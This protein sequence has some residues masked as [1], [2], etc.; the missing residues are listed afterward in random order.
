MTLV[1]WTKLSRLAAEP[2]P[3]LIKLFFGCFALILFHPFLVGKFVLGG[4]DV[5]YTHYPNLLFGYHEFELFKN[6]SLWNR[7]IFAGI[8]FTKSMH[9]HYL[10]PLYWPVFLFPEK[11]IFHVLTFLFIVINALIGWFWSR[12]AALSNVFSIGSLI[13]GIVAQ[14]GMF[15]WFAMTTFIAVPMYLYA[16]VIIYLIMTRELRSH[17]R[18]YITLSF[19]LGLLLVTPHPTYTLGFILPVI[20]VFLVSLYPHWLTP[21]RGFSAIFFM[22]C[23]T[24]LLFAAYRLVPVALELVTQGNLLSQLGITS[25]NSAYFGL[26]VSNPLAFG[27]NIHD[28]FQFAHSLTMT[29]GRHTQMHNA[30]YFGVTPLV[31]VYTALRAKLNKPLIIFV[32][33]Y[34]VIQLS[35]L[36]VQP[37]SEVVYL[38]FFPLGHEGLFRPIINITFLFLLINSLIVFSAIDKQRLQKIIKE[39]FLIVLLISAVLLTMYT[40]ILCEQPDLIGNYRFST[41]INFSRVSIIALLIGSFVI[42]QYFF[43]SVYRTRLVL[44]AIA[45]I[46][47]VGGISI[48]SLAFQLFPNTKAAIAI[49]K[50]E[51]SVFLLCSLFI[52]MVGFSLSKLQRKIV[53]TAV[54]VAILTVFLLSISFYSHAQNGYISVALLGWCSF[55]MLLMTTLILLERYSYDN[56]NIYLLF[57][58]FFILIV[59]DLLVSFTNYSYVN[60]PST[61]FIKKIEDIYPTSNLLAF[62]ETNLSNEKKLGNLLKNPEMH[63][64]NGQPDNWR[65]G[66]SD[67]ALCNQTNTI[68]HQKNSIC[69][70][71]TKND[72]GR[73][74]FQDV[75]LSNAVKQVSLGVWVRGEPGV[76]I[77]LFLTS[78]THNAGSIIV[79]QKGDGDWHWLVV[80]L[81][82]SQLFQD[83][84]AHINLASVGKVE[85]YA[86]RLVYGRVVQPKAQPSNNL[87]SND[88]V[89]SVPLKINLASYRINRVNALNFG[90]NELMNNIGM[91]VQ[92]PSYSGVDSDL[93]T[94]YVNFLQAF[95]KPD[96]SWFHRA[97]LVSIL[98]NTRLLDLLGVAYDTD[99][100]SGIKIRPNAISRFAAFSNYEVQDKKNSL[101]RL[102]DLAFDPTKTVV[103]DHELF[104]IPRI[105]KLKKFQPLNYTIKKS[106][107]LVLKITDKTPRIVLFNDRFSPSWH[108]Y[109]NDKPLKIVHANHLFMAVALPKGEGE[110]TFIFYPILFFRLCYLAAIVTM[111]LFGLWVIELV[112]QL[113]AFRKQK[114]NLIMG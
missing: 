9:A 6:F 46:A 104:G 112:V 67:I 33:I 40:R 41:I 70:L 113:L 74:L 20:S 50:G 99:P 69:V 73:N 15:F 3:I 78:P 5:L 28:S 79:K 90:T 100:T 103:L 4:T 107:K 68:K 91:V 8:D 59:C 95:E 1:S 60:V 96:A 66:G 102:Q 51:L 14:A 54:S 86:P 30:L 48:L 37:L 85:I 63:L 57:K 62:S 88:L 32:A 29:G 87:K 111:F 10:N 61:P 7:Y 97:G 21:W 11:Y 55:L 27:I 82:L 16:T 110:L 42:Y 53:I 75:K 17:L 71:Y 31:L 12:I 108:A 58:F 83:V 38:L 52:V 13:V 80:S 56:I 25:N 43:S 89:K 105:F 109:W 34:A 23:I 72:G 65:L 81:Q 26:T 77:G 44:L 36:T 98:E 76:S 45:S 24:A 106:D 39:C 18:N 35:Y 19:T 92:T 84:R 64:T 47:L 94:D 2:S 49:F 22:A 93:P 114:G 101:R